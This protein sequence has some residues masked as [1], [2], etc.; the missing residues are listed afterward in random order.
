[1][2]YN[3]SRLDVPKKKKPKL[4][5]QPSSK[6]LKPKLGKLSPQARAALARTYEARAKLDILIASAP[7]IPAID[8][9]PTVLVDPSEFRHK[10]FTLTT[11]TLTC[12]VCLDTWTPLP[13]NLEH[14]ILSHKQTCAG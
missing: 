1:M 9:L 7:K 4:S 8:E 12:K 13:L 10:N 6:P 3:L 14:V 2:Q 11:D 5:L